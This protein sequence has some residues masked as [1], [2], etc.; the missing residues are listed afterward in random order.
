MFHRIGR[1]AGVSD[2]EG[3][4]EDACEQRRHREQPA[5]LQAWS[6]RPQT[7]PSE[8]LSAHALGHPIGLPVALRHVS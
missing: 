7:T 3:R 8:R 4:R 1:P 6:G 5:R 2:H